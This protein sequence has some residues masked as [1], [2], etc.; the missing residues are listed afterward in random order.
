VRNNYEEDASC[1]KTCAMLLVSG[2]NLDSDEFTRLVEITPTETAKAGE[3]TGWRLSSESHVESTSAERHIH[4]ILDRIETKKGLVNQIK[5]RGCQVDVYCFWQGF[6]PQSIQG[7]LITPS[8]LRRVAE[9]DMN[10]IFG[11]KP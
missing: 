9:F 3:C 11:F 5:L 10:L 4:W 1:K 6:A 2:D 8:T 7:P